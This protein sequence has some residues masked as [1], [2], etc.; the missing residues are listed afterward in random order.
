M[1]NLHGY[2]VLRAVLAFLSS[3]AVFFTVWSVWR[4]LHARCIRLQYMADLGKALCHLP[5]P[6]R[7]Y[8]EFRLF[9]RH[10]YRTHAIR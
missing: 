9:L 8:V 7:M 6:C 5:V 3:V 1:R 2:Y 4:R 10:G